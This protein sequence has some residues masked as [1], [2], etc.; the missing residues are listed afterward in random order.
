MHGLDTIIVAPPSKP[1]SKG[2]AAS[3]KEVLE[4][5]FSGAGPVGVGESDH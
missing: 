4:L 5:A 2:T 3:G 1:G